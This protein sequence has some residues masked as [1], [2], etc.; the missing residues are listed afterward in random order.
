[1]IGIILSGH[2]HFATGLQSSLN[3]IAG[4]LANFAAIDFTGDLSIEDLK[5]KMSDALVELNKNCDHTIIFTDL[6]GG[7]P[8]QAAAMVAMEN[9]NVSVLAGTN[10]PMLIEING[11]RAFMDDAEMLLQ[12][13]SPFQAAAMVAMENSNVSVLAGTNLPMLI[14][15]NGARA[16]MDDAEMLVNMALSTGKEQIARLELSTIMAN[17]E[18]GD[19]A[20]G[21]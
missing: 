18:P 15:I 8:F 4:D 19:D 17:D 21:I 12:G 2:N 20:D 9:S 3:L 10:L 6:Q 14:E 11:A 16:F 5:A 1:M 13:G 7:S